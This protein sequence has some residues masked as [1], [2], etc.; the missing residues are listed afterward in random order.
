MTLTPKRIVLL[1]L[2]LL[3]LGIAAAAGFSGWRS[4]V[5]AAQERRAYETTMRLLDESRPVE[6]LTVIRTVKSATPDYDAGKWLPL[7][8]RALEQSR[9]IHRLLYLYGQYP[10]EVLKQEKAS[11]LISR[12]LLEMKNMEVFSQVRDAWRDR[13]KSPEVW[14]ALDVDALLMQGKVDE[15]SA[16]LTSRTFEGAADCGRLIRLAIL[17]SSEDMDEAWKLLEEAFR[18]DPRNPDVRSFRAQ[19]LEHAGATARARVEYVAAH[20]SDPRNP[21]LRD[22]LAEFHRRHGNYTLALKTW[23][24][25]LSPTSLDFLWIKALF[26]AKVTHPAEI[27]EDRATPPPGE[28]TPLIQAMQGMDPGEFWDSTKLRGDV[29]LEKHAE[30][31]QEVYWL[32]LL[33]ALK[34]GSEARAMDLLKAR[35]YRYASFHPELERALQIIL[36][37]RRWGVLVD[38]APGT[39]RPA[40]S[41]RP[42]HQFFETLDSMTMK[43]EG[44]AGQGEIPQEL[45][46]LLRSEEVFSAAFLAGGWLEAALSLHRLPVIPEAFPDWVAYGL[47]Q[48]LRYNRG[49]REALDFA[50]KQPRTP[51]LD[52]LIAEVMLA[53]NQ[54]GNAVPRLRS[55]AR[56]DSAVGFRA[57]WLLSLASLKEGDFQ[58]SRR[59]VQEYKALSSS[60][61]GQ[62]ILAR[63]ALNEGDTEDADRTY[64]RIA[65]ASLEAKAYLA[66]RAFARK[67][68]KTARKYTEDLLEYFPDMMELHENIRR[69]AQEEKRGRP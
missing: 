57:A 51:E 69:I 56:Q 59:I 38:P 3:V 45:D 43:K 67:D 1:C 40:A 14:F 28:W 33:Q 37:Y 48:A 44:S 61:T 9:N 10:L 47:T 8:I 16:M 68:W 54:M 19:V 31:R 21:L 64:A 46:T 18:A 24:D 50:V 58:E 63:I 20:L 66:R 35:P 39:S 17:K 6:A 52:L 5:I 34:D 4:Y 26:W 32:K 30:S 12:S 41:R 22:Q 27:P 42:E 2:G 7:E 13:A 55:L 49:N 36:V 23:I 53:D 65:G 25:G 62:E 60:V 29:N 15:A 11:A